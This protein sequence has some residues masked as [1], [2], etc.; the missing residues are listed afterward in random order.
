MPKIQISSRGIRA[1]LKKYTPYQ[2]IAEYVWNGFDAGATKIDIE[3]IADELGGLVSL[4]IKDNGYG[5]NHGKLQE[6]FE[7][8]FESRKALENKLKQ[9]RSALH[10]KKGIG[11]LTFF[12]FAR[13]AIW[14]TVFE[15]DDKNY[16]YDIFANSENINFYTGINSTPKITEKPVGTQV[17]FSA[18]HA[19][20]AANLEDKFK[21]FLCKEFAWFLELNSKSNFSININGL[22]LDC[23]HFIAE[24]E[25]FEIIHE[26]T[27]TAFDVTYVRWNEKS[28]NEPSRYYYLNS[29]DLE[30]WKEPTAIKNKGE[31]FYHSVFIKSNYFDSFAFQ[32][33]QDSGQEA[34]IGGSRSDT[35]FRFLRRKLANYLRIKRRPFLKTFA[36]NLIEEYRE[37]NI[38]PENT[39]GNFEQT[40]KTLYEIQPRIFS[41]LNKEQ[42]KLFVNMLSLLNESNK[43]KAITQTIGLVVDLS[44]EEK[45]ELEKLFETQ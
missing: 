45:T 4:S 23:A 17:T 22:P 9:H 8:M 37:Q 2:S 30:Q 16:T 19:L 20:T 14:N 7:P 27:A 43:R 18:I 29:A 6:K 32:S 34:L 10:G 12:T 44:E 24:K 26:K 41:A 35:Q 39:D 38:L 3:Y 15:K 1:A 31:K 36:Q 13:S 28:A 40:I 5:I 33:M 25:T 11:R 42:K 21:E